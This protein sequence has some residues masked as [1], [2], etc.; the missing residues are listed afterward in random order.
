MNESILNSKR[1]NQPSILFN[2]QKGYP[3]LSILVVEYIAILIWES[4][5]SN[6]FWLNKVNAIF[7]TKIEF[8]HFILL[9]ISG[10]CF[11]K[12]VNNGAYQACQDS[13]FY[14]SLV[15]IQ[16]YDTIH[17]IL[18]KN[19]WTCCI[20]CE[21]IIKISVIIPDLCLNHRSTN[22]DKRS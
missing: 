21:W 12:S 20:W 4:C 17:V 13:I 10:T 14:F 16:K 8:S 9:D 18:P 7:L 3:I 2:W 11:K 6:V 19:N 1:K 5:H 15:S 22:L